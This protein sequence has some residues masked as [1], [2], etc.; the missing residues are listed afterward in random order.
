MS[1]L[2]EHFLRHVGQTSLSPLMI[3]VAKAEGI[4]FYT[5]EGKR[6]FDLLRHVL[7][8]GSSNNII[9][10]YLMKKYDYL[11]GTTVRNKL[12]DINAWFMPINADEWR[13]NTLL[14]QNPYYVT[15]SNIE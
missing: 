9:S 5:P 8:D 12:I 2:R 4:F 11:V 10:S 6:Y 1:T 3:E 13:I 14:M 7:R 15:S